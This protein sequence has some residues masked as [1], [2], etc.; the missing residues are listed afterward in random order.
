MPFL[1]LVAKK[2]RKKRRPDVPSGT[3]LRACQN[4]RRQRLQCFGGNMQIQRLR[5]RFDNKTPTRKWYA[6]R[7]LKKFC[8]VLRPP[9]RTN[10]KQK[11]ES[12][13][14]CSHSAFCILHSAF[15]IFLAPQMEDA[16]KSTPR[17]SL[18]ERREIRGIQGGKP[19]F[20]SWLLLGKCQE[21]ASKTQIAN[22][23]SS[24]SVRLR[25]Q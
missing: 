2:W 11:R 5:C 4:C 21:V 22:A 14:R 16:C 23:R 17:R 8:R 13:S 19:W 7:C 9:V 10:F 15:C 20:P 18:S 3:S 25:R 24:V 12:K 6:H 1:C